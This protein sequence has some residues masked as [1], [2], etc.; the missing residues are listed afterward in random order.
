MTPRTL[1]IA[2]ASLLAMS[3]AAGSVAATSDRTPVLTL[4]PAHGMSTDIGA[5]RAV[6][7]FLSDSRICN[8]TI[9]VSEAMIEGDDTIPAPTRLKFDV[10]AGSDVRLDTTD[11]K[12]LAFGCATDTASMSIKVL[13]QMA[14]YAPLR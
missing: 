13:E 5:K 9:L 4:K 10:P 2:A 3:A 7:Y 11:G 6:G 14:A 8:L 1:L 12:A